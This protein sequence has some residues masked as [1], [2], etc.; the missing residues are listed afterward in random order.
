MRLPHNASIKPLSV[1]ESEAIMTYKERKLSIEL[2]PEPLWKQSLHGTLKRSQWDKIRKAVY[3]RQNYRCGICEAQGR[4]LCHEIWQYDDAR[5]VQTLTGFIAIC[6]MCNNVKHLGRAGIIALEGKLDYAQVIAHYM[7]VNQCSRQDFESDKTDAFAQ[8]KRRS[9]HQDWKIEIGDFTRLAEAAI[10]QEIFNENE[11]NDPTPPTQATGIWLYAICDNLWYPEH[12]ERS[13]KWLVFLPEE[14]IDR[15]WQLVCLSLS[16]W[17]LGSE[18]K[19]S[20]AAKKRHMDSSS[21]IR[22]HP[23]V[24]KPD[25][26]VIVVY[27]YD[28]ADKADVMRIREELYNIGIRCPISYKSDEQTYQ[29]IYSNG[30]GFAPLY[31][32]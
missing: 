17:R 26:Y 11:V 21:L 16:M 5:H 18:A 14:E 13:G 12:T 2:V 10:S 30:D 8:W 9:Q 32:V 23:T 31:R 3:A 4:L 15:Y 19:V 27:T 24:R 1:S 7:R 22:R 29:G 28:Y 20:T 6:D 25:N